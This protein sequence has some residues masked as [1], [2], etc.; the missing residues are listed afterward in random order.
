MGFLHE[1]DFQSWTS[2][3]ISPLI[4]KAKTP[5]LDIL[6]ISLVVVLVQTMSV[7]RVMDLNVEEDGNEE[8]VL[9]F[10]LRRIKVVFGNNANM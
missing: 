9:L 5:T 7:S 2:L 4:S 1:K 8:V 10:L 3:D 6:P